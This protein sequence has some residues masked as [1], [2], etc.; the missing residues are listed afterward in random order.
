MRGYAQL[1]REQRYQ[2]HAM[3]KLGHSQ[4]VMAA[5]IGVHKSTISRELSRN[6]GHVGYRP[7]RAHGLALARRRSKGHVRIDAW[8]WNRVEG[9]LRLQWSPQQIGERLWQE[10]GT[11]VSHEW[12]YQ[13]VYADKR[14]GG[15]LHRHL[16][17]QK[18][19]RKRYG[20]HD[21]RGRVPHRV[22]I[23]ARPAAAARRSRLGDWEVDTVVGQRSSGGALLTLVDRKSRYTLLGRLKDKTAPRVRRA[24]VR[25][26]RPHSNKRH[27]LTY[28][29]S[30]EFAEHDE[31]AKALGL[32]SYFARP[33]APWQRGTNENTNGLIRQYFPKSSDFSVITHAQVQKVVTRLNLRPRKCLGFKTP[34]E[35]FF[36]TKLSLTRC[37]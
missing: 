24:T 16:R 28:D 3:K 18:V 12:I 14:A 17:C 20:H 13:Y 32:K 33:H 10:T 31:V 30:M 8:T 34:H 4:A 9:L 22:G 26:L 37:T 23:E 7:G 11:Q 5:A 2:I 35:V 27:T 1:T 25:L 36:N 21:R 6:G 29:N 19:H 15:E